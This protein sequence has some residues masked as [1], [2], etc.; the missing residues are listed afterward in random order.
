MLTIRRAMKLSP[1]TQ[2]KV[3]PANNPQAASDLESP[4]SREE[5]LTCAADLL[6]GQFEKRGYALPA[7]YRVALGWPRNRRALGETAGAEFS[8][9]GTLE[10][11]ISPLV[12]NA[13]TALDVL[14]HEACHA[15]TGKHHRSAFIDAARAMGLQGKG[16]TM[17][18]RYNP[19]W[20]AWAIPLAA[21]LGDF[22][23]DAML[24]DMKRAAKPSSR[25]IKCACPKCRRI[26]RTTRKALTDIPQPRCIDPSCAGER[27]SQSS[28]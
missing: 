5:W 10:T 23:H 8:S 14:T 25:S 17:T 22:P 11:F 9:T 20:Q 2:K 21:K 18:G 27:C 28:D 26:I 15:L 12:A 16:A 6:R 1:T 3:A 4:V 7:A 13:L 19:T 24:L